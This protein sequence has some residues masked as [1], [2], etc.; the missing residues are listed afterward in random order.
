MTL[1]WSDLTNDEREFLRS[2]S[3]LNDDYKRLVG[4]VLDVLAKRR[5][6][7]AD[8]RAF[9]AMIEAG[10]GR[11]AARILIAKCGVTIALHAQGASDA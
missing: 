7:P 11:D 9:E 4:A 8:L 6:S 10:Q 3:W 2:Y 5:H 1:T